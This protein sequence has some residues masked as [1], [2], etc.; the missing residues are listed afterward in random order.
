MVWGAWRAHSTRPWFERL[1]NLAVACGLI[2]LS[3][4]LMIIVAVAVKCDSHG[5]VLV[6]ERRATPRGRQFWALK[7][8]STVHEATAC[9]FD[10]EETTFVGSIIHVLRLDT[11]PQL[12]NVLR[13]EMT[14]L[15]GDPDCLFFLE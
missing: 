6:W 14:C 12:V 9:S 5:P 15:P 10:E 13:G 8:R 4:P 2:A 7:F 3:L 1:G 11:L